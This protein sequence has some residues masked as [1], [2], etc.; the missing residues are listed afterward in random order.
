MASQAERA[1]IRPHDVNVREALLP[2]AG[3][4]FRAPASRKVPI[5]QPYRVLLLV[6]QHNAIGPLVDLIIDHDISRGD[7][8]VIASGCLIKDQDD[9]EEA[10][11]IK[12]LH[13]PKLLRVVL[14]SRPKTSPKLV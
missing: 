1:H 12:E 11:R 14:S 6:V 3:R 9:R 5:R 8:A 10:A 4:A 7:T 2:G 13:L